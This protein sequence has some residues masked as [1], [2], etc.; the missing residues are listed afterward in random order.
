MTTSTYPAT[1]GFVDNTSAANFIPEHWSDEVIAAEKANLVMAGLCRKMNF[2]G[3]KGDTVHV[4]KPARGSANAKAENTAVTVQ[5]DTAGVLDISIDRH[6]EYSYLIEDIT[7]T[8]ALS[9]LRKFITDD[10]GYALATQKDT[11]LLSVGK[12]WGDGDGAD[13]IHSNSFYANAGT[14]LSAYAA[15]T[16]AAGD[17]LTDAVIRLAILELDNADVPMTNR[18]WVV[19]PIAKSDLLGVDR[20]NSADFTNVQKG[21]VT[22]RFGQAYGV[23]FYTSTNVPI[24]ETAANNDAGDDV[25]GSQLFHR[26]AIVLVEQQAVRSQFQYKQE[27]LGNLYTSD[28]LYGFSEYQL[29]HGIVVAVHG[30]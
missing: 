20:L 25:Y 19:P 21:V 28:T 1:G 30:T 23:D 4:P 24:I 27:W 15:D 22:G 10:A 5:N 29:E 3:K 2:T 6:F 7:S 14:S 17:D 26:D 13:W 18:S 16:V 12:S 8:Q 9:S 11:D